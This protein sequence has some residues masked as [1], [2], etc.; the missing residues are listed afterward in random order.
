MSNLTAAAK[1]VDSLARLHFETRA[2]NGGIFPHITNE[3]GSISTHRMAAEIDENTGKWHAFPT[4]VQN[5]DGTLSQFKDS[6]EAMKHNMRTGNIKEMPSKEA[7]L[8]YAQGGYKK[9]TYMDHPAIDDTA[10][11]YGRAVANET[12]SPLAAALTHALTQM[13]SPI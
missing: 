2:N 13:A 6:R 8:D 3:D 10:S 1:L 7:A 11:D 4:I 9:G 5:R 12:G